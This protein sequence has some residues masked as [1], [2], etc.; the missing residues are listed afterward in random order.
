MLFQ[1]VVLDVFE[2]V[3]SK[4]LGPSPRKP[5]E[6]APEAQKTFCSSAY[7]KFSKSSF[8]LAGGYSANMKWRNAKVWLG[9]RLILKLLKVLETSNFAWR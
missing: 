3:E 6:K 5:L 2:G 4:K 1:T 9:A 7:T 8:L